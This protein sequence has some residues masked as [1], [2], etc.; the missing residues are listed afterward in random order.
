MWKEIEQH[1]A[2]E[3]W[4]GARRAIRKALR[5]E[6][7]SH[8]LLSRLALTFYEEFQYAEALALE[9]RALALAPRCPLVL[10][11]KA[12]SLEMLGREAE[13]IAVFKRILKR[14]KELLA[15]G[16]CGEGMARA[17]G[18]YADCLYR[19]GHCYAALGRRADAV[20]YL[21]RHLA[22]RGPG[23]HSIYQLRDVRREFEALSVSPAQPYYQTRPG[24]RIC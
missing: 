10:W 11:G 20:R 14:G 8:W 2:E 6:Q 12:G 16:E 3:D 15:Y 24:D 1:I 9:E 13:A 17:R 4:R 7:E 21:N 22:E 18:L 23:C 5:R 19:A